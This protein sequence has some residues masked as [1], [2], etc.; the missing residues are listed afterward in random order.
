MGHTLRTGDGERRELTV[1]EAGRL[2]AVVAGALPEMTRARVQRLIAQGLVTVNG[3]PARK[4]ARV[5]RGDVVAVSLPARPRAPRATG[6]R[7]RVLY[8]DECLVAIDKPPGV[9]VHAGPGDQQAP[10]VA[11][12]FVER[13]PDL[14][15]AF[16]AERPGIVHRL[17][18]DT[19][20]VLLLAKTPVAQAALS[21]AFETRAVHKR[22]VAL[23]DGVPDR[24]H[25]VIEAPIGRHPGDRTRMAVTPRTRGRA[26]TTEY[27]LLGSARGRSL[28]LLKPVTGRTHQIRVHLAAV[29]LPIVGDHVYGKRGAREGRQLLH[30]WQ[31]EVPHPAGG[32]LL[33]TAP[34]AE[35]MA[36]E[37]RACGLA[38]VAL[39]Y[40]EERAAQRVEEAT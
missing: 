22:Y 14:A 26:A 40:H 6:L 3:E 12:W 32:R 1:A 13:Y 39:A 27:E 9:A 17:D 28:V 15:A 20:G 21:R 25:A 30:A 7:F 29:G 37:I 8:E 31:L 23:C 34:L 18:K 36:T 4:S 5:E 33:V 24:P 2:D 10:T 38:D 11:A 19:S 16:E 35:D